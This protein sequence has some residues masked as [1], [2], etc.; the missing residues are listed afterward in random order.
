MVAVTPGTDR[1]VKEITYA[2][3]GKDRS[4]KVVKDGVR[5]A[6][7]VVVSFMLRRQGYERHKNKENPGKRQHQ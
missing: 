1:R 4:N 6:G 2:W 5:A 3:E 7:A